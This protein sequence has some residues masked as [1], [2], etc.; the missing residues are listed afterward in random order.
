M[1]NER[2]ARIETKLDTLIDQSEDK[3]SRIRSLEKNQTKLLAWA[4]GAAGMVS[5]AFQLL[6]DKIH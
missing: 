6:K 1:E 3:E 5:I 4:S 2:L